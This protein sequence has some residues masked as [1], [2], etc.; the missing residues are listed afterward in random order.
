[1]TASQGSERG[2]PVAWQTESQSAALLNDPL[3]LPPAYSNTSAKFLHA[4]QESIL[5][6]MVD[7][8]QFVCSLA[9]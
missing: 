6:W 7:A 5:E 3:N 1:M 4:C 9:A 8:M 2:T